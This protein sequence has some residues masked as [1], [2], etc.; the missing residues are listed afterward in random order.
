MLVEKKMY[1][2]LEELLIT[3]KATLKS[4]IVNCNEFCLTK[5]NSFQLVVEEFGTIICGIDRNEYTNINKI[6]EESF[7]NYRKVFCTIFDD[8]VERRDSIIWALMSGGYIR[9]IRF[10]YKNQF[11]NFIIKE[12]FSNRIIDERLKRWSDRP[13]YRAYIEDNIAAKN[14]SS[15]FLLSID[16]G[17]YDYMPEEGE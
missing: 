14:M 15:T 2:E 3:T 11:R 10:N 13:K 16:P 9:W 12:N 7:P 17:F 4:L 5:G 8:P 1:E 6:V